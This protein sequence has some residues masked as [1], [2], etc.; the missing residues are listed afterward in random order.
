MLIPIADVPRWYAERTA[1]CTIAARLRDDT[2]NWSNLERGPNRRAR[3]GA[4]SL[5]FARS[6]RWNGD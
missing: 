6:I 2:L 5:S 4:Q 3:E 1:S